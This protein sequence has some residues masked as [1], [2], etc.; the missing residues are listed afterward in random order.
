M[1]ARGI[2]AHPT[3]KL[4]LI[5]GTAHKPVLLASQFFDA[6]QVPPFDPEDDNLQD[7]P[8]VLGRNNQIGSCG[9]TTCANDLVA[10]TLGE[11]VPSDDD[12]VRFYSY[13]SGYDPSLDDEPGGNPT[14]VGVDMQDMLEKLMKVGMGDGKGGVIKPVAFAKLDLA[15]EAQEAAINAFNGCAQ[16]VDLETAQQEQTDEDPP[17]WDYVRSG[18]WGGHAIFSGKYVAKTGRITVI[19]WQQHVEET[20]EFRA[21]QE[22]E[23]WLIIWPQ[24]LNAPGVDV[25]KL[26]E[27]YKALTGR[28]LPIPDPGPNPGPNPDPDPGPSPAPSNALQELEAFID[29]AVEEFKA[30]LRRLFG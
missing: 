21:E 19:T 16:A 15:D 20:T 26:A 24:N 28:D 4:G 22:Q 11:I 27:V 10:T 8:F 18:E 2:H 30:L 9:P 25:A 12:V 7:L 1:P 13:V 29:R 23:L 5:R 3:R 6:S 17:V 14:D